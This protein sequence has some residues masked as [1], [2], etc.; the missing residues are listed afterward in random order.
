LH[1]KIHLAHQLQPPVA[2]FPTSFAG[3]NCHYLLRYTQET[4]LNE[5]SSPNAEHPNCMHVEVHLSQNITV[6]KGRQL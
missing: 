3:G 4:V 1:D 6:W 5:Q 2:Q